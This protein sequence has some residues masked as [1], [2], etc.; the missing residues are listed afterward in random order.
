[1]TSQSAPNLGLSL[2]I[3]DFEIGS[4]ATDTR[5]SKRKPSSNYSCG[6][7]LSY[8]AACHASWAWS[9]SIPA[10]TYSVPACHTAHI[11]AVPLSPLSNGCVRCRK[12]P[13]P[14]TPSP[15]VTCLMPSRCGNQG[16]SKL[17]QRMVAA[18]VMQATKA[19]RGSRTKLRL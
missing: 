3:P 9:H 18:R 8:A 16:L 19:A 6:A 1:M 12:T 15:T 10:S 5:F 14:K 17:V 7:L 4:C 2:E 11:L 13:S